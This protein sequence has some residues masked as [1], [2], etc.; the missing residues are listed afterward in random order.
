MAVFPELL[1]FM[2]SQPFTIPMVVVTSARHEKPLSALS[3]V[4]AVGT[5]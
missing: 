5:A 2:L 1:S 4:W 3:P